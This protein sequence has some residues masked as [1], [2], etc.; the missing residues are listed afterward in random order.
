MA[1]VW[2]VLGHH[3]TRCL[4]E[5]VAAWPDFSS[6]LIAIRHLTLRNGVFTPLRLV[7]FDAPNHFQNRVGEPAE[8]GELSAAG[9][10]NSLTGRWI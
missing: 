4:S 6:S 5:P 7:L 9:G 3:G 8:H 10:V 2:T 1:R